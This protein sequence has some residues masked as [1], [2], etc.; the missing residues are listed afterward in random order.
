M[1]EEQEQILLSDV[2]VIKDN[3][4]GMKDSIGRHSSTLYGNGQDGIVGKVKG[5]EKRR[6]SQKKANW[7]ILGGLVSFLFTVASAIALT[8]IM[9]K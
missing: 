3:V 1:K 6:D 7:I 5:L 9:N 2:A 8:Y 4:E